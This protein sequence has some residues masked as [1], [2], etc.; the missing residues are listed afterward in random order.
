MGTYH[1]KNEESDSTQR[2]FLSI[3]M[4]KFG[5]ASCMCSARIAKW[6]P[7]T[8]KMNKNN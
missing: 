7:F 8:G 3:Q 5:V 4:I 2:Q 1:Y 6:F